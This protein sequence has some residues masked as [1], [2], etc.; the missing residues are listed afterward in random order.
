MAYDKSRS[1][2]EKIKVMRKMIL[3]WLVTNLIYFALQAQTMEEWFKQNDTQK[4]Y[5]LRQIAYLQTYGGYVKD[6]IDIAQKGLGIISN[7]KKGDYNLHANYFKSLSVINP[8]I[9]NYTRIADI[10]TIQATILRQYKKTYNKARASGQ[11]NDKEIKY[12][13]HVYINLL[14]D[15]TSNVN[16]LMALTTAR[17]LELKDDER[18]QRIDKLHEEMEDKYCFMQ[19]FSNGVNLLALQRQQDMNDVK[20]TG[21]LYNIKK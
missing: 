15:C 5:L 16:D 7:I 8:S 21:A 14:S 9:R 6:G 11:F 18:L 20:N 4:E 17:K 12:M 10:V 2:N 13:Y 1:V 19:H 3:L